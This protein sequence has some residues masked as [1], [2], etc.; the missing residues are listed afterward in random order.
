[1]PPQC[2][3]SMASREGLFVLSICDGI[4]TVWVCLQI[5]GIS[6]HLIRGASAEHDP[7]LSAFLHHKYPRVACFSD[8]LKLEPRRILNM[9]KGCHTFLLSGGPPCQPFS[10]LSSQLGFSDARSDPLLAFFGLRDFFADQ[11]PRNGMQF[12]WFMEEVASMKECERRRVSDLAGCPPGILPSADFGW[13]HRNRLVWGPDWSRLPIS[14]LPGLEAN[15]PGSLA[16]DCWVLRWLGS[17]SPPT[18]APH[19]ASLPTQMAGTRNQKIPGILWRPEYPKGR[20]MT[21]TTCFPHPADRGPVGSLSV[22]E[23][24][25]QDKARFPLSQYVAGNLVVSSSGASRPLTADE[26]EELMGLPHQYTQALQPRQGVSHEDARCSA[27]GNGWHVPTM[28]MLLFVLLQQATSLHIPRPLRNESAI[29]PGS[30]RAQHIPGSFWDLESETLPE[31]CIP[32]DFLMKHATDMFPVSFFPTPLLR[33]FEEQVASI[34][35]KAYT[36][37]VRYARA[38]GRGNDIG[39]PDVCALRFKMRHH[40]AGEQQ[41]KSAGARSNDAS[42]IPRDLPPDDHIAMALDTPHPFRDSDGSGEL[43]HNFAVEGAARLGPDAGSWR[44][45]VWGHFRRLANACRDLDKFARSK[46]TAHHVEGKAPWMFAIIISALKWNDTSLPFD[47]VVGFRLFGTVPP[48]G[49]LRSLDFSSLP[50]MTGDEM[51]QQLLESAEEY[52]DLLERDLRVHPEGQVILKETE[53][54]IELGLLGP[55][56]N[57][58]QLDARFGRGNWRPI[59][60]HI[61][62]QN[63]KDRPIDDGKAGGHNESSRLLETIATQSS[64]E[65]V[66]LTVSAFL[67][68]CDALVGGSPPSVDYVH[69]GIGRPVEGVP[70]GS[71]APRRCSFLHCHVRPPCDPQ[72]GV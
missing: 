26:R 46:R 20:F 71:P 61:V 64:T 47:S 63:G 43:D 50:T 3:S 24:F 2:L 44:N 11:C 15:P 21:F 38:H 35:F 12:L 14:M 37:F 1:M 53:S 6:P 55:L 10:C 16:P 18:W 62:H 57:R 28:T 40:A 22:M 48:S 33:Q 42:L 56:M 23:S 27:I 19:E 31:D 52:V 65:F 60:R 30:W 68:D 25:R 59:P 39:G 36:L 70:T 72:E 9:A 49:I 45:E 32:T 58:K 29:P 17:C 5:L 69:P 41:H 54:E 67:Q 34:N 8:A 51:R 13:L 66:V 7:L 4:G